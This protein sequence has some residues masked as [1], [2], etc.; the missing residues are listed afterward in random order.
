MEL[1]MKR[2]SNAAFA[3][4]ILRSDIKLV[5]YPI[6]RIVLMIVLLAAMWSLIF[7]LSAGQVEDSLSDFTTQGMSLA[8][9]AGTQTQDAHA[10]NPNQMQESPQAQKMESDALRIFE[11]INYLWL[12][13]FLILNLLIGILSTGA[14]TGQALAVIRGEKR[15]LGYGYSMALLRFPQLFVWWLLTLIVGTLLQILESHRAIGL[16][17]AAVIGMAWT[18]LTFFSITAIMATG[19]GPFRAIKASKNT[20]KD[21]WKK[22][23]GETNPGGYKSLRRGLYVGG[24]FF[25]INFLLII[26]F[27]GLLWFD[28][29]SWGHSA[30]H[31]SFGAFAAIGVVL[32]INGAFMSAMWAIVKS[33]I[34]IWAEEGKLP[35]TVDESVMQ[36]AFYQPKFSLAKLTERKTRP[37]LQG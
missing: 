6:L 8:G 34:Y 16:I 4:D 30:H 7:D 29:R 22:C 33:T 21:T 36:H 37:P 12:L 28:F 24:P 20:V 3:W 25:I 23:T 11:N 9:D 32:Y 14:L 19:C 15:S 5:S 13:V 18:I 10:G 31:V 27:I 1:K 35:E 2:R 26:A 17:V